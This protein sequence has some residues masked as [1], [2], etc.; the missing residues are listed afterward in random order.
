VHGSVA[1]EDLRQAVI[2]YR[3]LFSD[4]LGEPTDG[5]EPRITA[6]QEPAAVSAAEP[7]GAGV[8]EPGEVDDG[9]PVA[10]AAELDGSPVT[11]P[12][13]EPLRSARR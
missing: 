6:G 12:D 13:V 2:H 3:E 10:S 5:A 1:T 4:L 11:D 7:D 8:V 9:E